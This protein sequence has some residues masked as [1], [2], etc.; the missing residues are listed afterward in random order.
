MSKKIIEGNPKKHLA[1]QEEVNRRFKGTCL[2]QIKN[3][4]PVITLENVMLFRNRCFK[5]L[6]EVYKSE[7]D[8]Y[9][10]NKYLENKGVRQS[11]LID[12]YTEY[13]SSLSIILGHVSNAYM[14]L[15]EEIRKKKEV[16]EKTKQALA[17]E[18]LKAPEEAQKI[19]NNQSMMNDI[20][21]SYV[22]NKRSNRKGFVVRYP[23]PHYKVSQFV[24][25]II[26]PEVVRRGEE[27]LIDLEAKFR[28]QAQKVREQEQQKLI[29]KQ[30][31]EE[32]VVKRMKELSK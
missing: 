26:E 22:S 14:L 16:D 29:E 10:F 17:L 1:F 20:V 28:I 21:M 2:E 3:E 15:E 5:R 24:I 11:M 8:E 18:K 25:D 4:Y 13:Y 9:T 30:K 7:M 23:N 27:R 19:L 12:G 31:F 6:N 32:A